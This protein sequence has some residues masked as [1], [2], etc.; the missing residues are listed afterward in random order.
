MAFC[1]CMN[2]LWRFF[3]GGAHCVGGFYVGLQYNRHRHARAPAAAV[4]RVQYSAERRKLQRTARLCR[5]SYRTG[6]T[7]V[8]KFKRKQKR[9]KKRKKRQVKI[10]WDHRQR[11]RLIRKQSTESAHE[12]AAD[13]C[14]EPTVGKGCFCDSCVCECVRPWPSSP[15]TTGYSGWLVVVASPR[16]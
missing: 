14:R 11:N 12:G 13:N 10:R 3:R 7:E 6:T 16:K 8:V 5:A 1:C 2:E 15:M 4:S 9:K